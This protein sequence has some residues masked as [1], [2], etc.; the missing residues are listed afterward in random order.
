MKKLVRLFV[1]LSIVLASQAFASNCKTGVVYSL[2]FEPQAG[3]KNADFA[4]T[5]RFGVRTKKGDSNSAY[6]YISPSQQNFDV[7][8]DVLLTAS[9]HKVAIEVCWDSNPSPAK[10]LYFRANQITIL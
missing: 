6:A 3:A 2:A 8:Y 5:A 4:G 1:M 7:L 9:I 10:G